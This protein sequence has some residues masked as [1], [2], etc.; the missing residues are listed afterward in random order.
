MP[1]KA[2]PVMPSPVQAVAAQ[3]NAGARPLGAHSEQDAAAAVRAMFDEIAP[4]Y[5]FLNHVL[6][7]NIDRLWWWRTARRFRAVL[8][9]PEA[10]VLDLCCGTGDMTMALVRR[11]PKESVPVL[12]ADFSHGM[13]KRGALKF[14]GRGAVAIEADAMQLPLTDGSLDLI[15]TA[16][17]FRNLR[18]YRGGLEEFLRVLKPGGQLGILDFAEPGGVLGRLYSFYFRRVLPWIGKRLSGSAGPYAYLPASVERFPAPAEL[19]RQM[20]ELGFVE[21]SWTAYSFGIAG[22]YV[23]NKA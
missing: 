6:S 2:K 1:D 14:S 8:G 3:A 20:R 19:M 7:L 17:G 23:A 9:R 4:R 13:L 11:R 12:A 10:R 18:N 15:V 21:V 5:D 16:F 22:L